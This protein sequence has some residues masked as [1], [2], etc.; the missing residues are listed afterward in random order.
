MTITP[1]INSGVYGEKCSLMYTERISMRASDTAYASLRDDILHWELPPG[2]VLAEV[3]QARRLSLSRTPI[4]EAFA[5][6]AAEGL[7]VAL[8][9]RGLVVSELSRETIV[10]LFELRRV[11]EAEAA[12]LAAMRRTVGVFAELRDEFSVAHL[13]LEDEAGL[14]AYYQLVER[15][16]KAM[17]AAVQS[18]F[19]VSA[20]RQLRPHLIRVRRLARDNPERLRQAANEHL[21]IVEAIVEGDAELAASTTSIHL[22]RSLKNI[23]AVIDSPEK[24]PEDAAKTVIS[25]VPKPPTGKENHG[26]A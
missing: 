11:L 12:R 18:R 7:L 8:P 17:D 1:L 19:L 5:R 14:R 3:E 9:G 20:I 4:R 22:K 16:D 26:S 23:L 24:A 15:L 2:T 21:M 6:L 10:E 13:L 25:A